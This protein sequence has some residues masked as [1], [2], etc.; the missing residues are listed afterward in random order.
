MEQLDAD[1]DGNGEPANEDQTAGDD[2]SM[3]DASEELQEDDHTRGEADAVD[4][5][6][7]ARKRIRQAL[8]QGVDPL[9][10]TGGS[11]G[12]SATAVLENFLVRPKSK[13]KSQPPT[14]D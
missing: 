3:H 1:F 8:E 12:S 9:G 7:E 10:L 11:T 6:A 14:Q 13:A 5:D 4:G 2:A